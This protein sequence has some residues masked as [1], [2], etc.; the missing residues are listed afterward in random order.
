MYFG[1]SLATDRPLF[2]SLLFLAKSSLSL[3]QPLLGR[4][5]EAKLIYFVSV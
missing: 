3:G 4:S 1:T 5:E 2:C